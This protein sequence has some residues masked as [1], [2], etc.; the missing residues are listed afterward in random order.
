LKEK[1]N[2]DKTYG[3]FQNDTDGIMTNFLNSHMPGFKVTDPIMTISTLFAS[4]NPDAVIR[5]NVLN[6]AVI[7][8]TNLTLNK[9]NCPK[10]FV[11][12]PMTGKKNACKKN[13]FHDIVIIYYHV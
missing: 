3:L 5:M 8:C 7:P 2:F 10:G 1:E 4:R 13:I 11:L 12:E 9:T 6:D